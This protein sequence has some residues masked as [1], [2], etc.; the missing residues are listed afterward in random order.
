M[1]QTHHLKYKTKQK[2]CY[3]DCFT[4]FLPQGII[5][6]LMCNVF[7]TFCSGAAGGSGACRVC[8]LALWIPCSEQECSPAVGQI[9]SLYS[10]GKVFT[11]ELL[12]LPLHS[13]TSTEDCTELLSSSV[14]IEYFQRRN[15]QDKYPLN[16]R[17]SLPNLEY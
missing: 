5:F 7:I 2:H 1:E 10:V 14:V 9:N 17:M 11:A 3:S 4:I 15:S 8:R 12:L 16:T 13:L 6:S